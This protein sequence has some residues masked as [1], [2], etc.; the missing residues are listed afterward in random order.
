MAGLT[1]WFDENVLSVRDVFWM[2]VG[3]DIGE[4]K[5][6]D[7]LWAIIQFNRV[8]FHYH[9]MYQQRTDSR[10]NHSCAACYLEYRELHVRSW[11]FHHSI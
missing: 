11:P 4:W 1:Q 10:S 2:V 7:T 3:L 6:P 5:E 8:K 9:E